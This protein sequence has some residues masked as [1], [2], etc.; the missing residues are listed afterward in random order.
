MDRSKQYRRFRTLLIASGRDRCRVIRTARAMG[1]RTVRFIPRRPRRVTSRWPDEACCSGRPGARTAI[2][3]SN[4]DRS[5]APERAE[6]VHPATVSVR[7][8]PNRAGPASTPDGIRGPTADDQGEGSKSGSKMLMEKAG[9]RWLPGYHGEAQDETNAREGSRKIG[10]RFW[11]R[12]RPVAA[13]RHAAS[14]ARGGLP[15]QSSAP[16]ARPR[17]VR[18]RSHADEKIWTIA[19]IECRS[20]VTAKAICCRCSSANA[21]CSRGIRRDRGSAIADTRRHA[22]RGV[23]AAARKRLP[24]WIMSVPGTIESSLDGKTSSH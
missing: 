11:S 17:R 16:S 2:S 20:S 7:E 13:P 5:G 22:T 8:L 10:F 1:L 6:A 21:R 18:R 15:P 3:T 12:P 23:C 24:R 14:C 4:A 19:H 9:G